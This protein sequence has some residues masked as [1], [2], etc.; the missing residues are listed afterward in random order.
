MSKKGPLSPGNGGVNCQTF[1]YTRGPFVPYYIIPMAP[2]P[3]LRPPGSPKNPAQ[4]LSGRRP[5]HGAQG[6]L[7]VRKP[8]VEWNTD[9]IDDGRDSALEVSDDSDEEKETVTSGQ[10]LENKSPSGG[11]VVDLLDIAR[12][13]KPKGVWC[14]LQ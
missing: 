11:Q 5:S 10:P 6:K 12:P 14:T 8:V 13:A 7:K 1:S 2:S 4:A 9:D 3:T